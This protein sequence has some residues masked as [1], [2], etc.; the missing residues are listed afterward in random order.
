MVV[1][2]EPR[3]RHAERVLEDYLD[4]LS[5]SELDHLKTCD[6]VIYMN[7]APCDKCAVILLSV[8]DYCCEGTVLFTALYTS[9]KQ[10]VSYKNYKGWKK[11]TENVTFGYMRRPDYICLK[12]KPPTHVKTNNEDHNDYAVGKM[13]ASKRD[14]VESFCET[15]V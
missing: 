5:E 1:H 9:R 7:W 2:N 6:F 3:G 12:I 11:L 13:P 8:I 15:M 10:S 14:K 4:K